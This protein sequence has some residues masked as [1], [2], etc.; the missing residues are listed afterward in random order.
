MGKSVEKKSFKDMKMDYS[1]IHITSKDV[2]G[3]KTGRWLM[4]GNKV[5]LMGCIEGWLALQEAEIGVDE[6]QV[7][8]A[9]KLFDLFTF[10][11][12]EESKEE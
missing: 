12:N 2:A 4:V 6:A 3:G 7:A 8:F 1:Q 10:G 9:Q 11:N 5:G